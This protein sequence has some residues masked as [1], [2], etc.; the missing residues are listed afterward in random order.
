[1]VPVNMH[2]KPVPVPLPCPIVRLG[3]IPMTAPRGAWARAGARAGGGSGSGKVVGVAGIPE[4]P[5]RTICQRPKRNLEFHS[6]GVASFSASNGGKPQGPCPGQNAFHPRKG[7][8]VERR[9]R[10]AMGLPPLRRWPPGCR[11]DG[12]AKSPSVP[13]R[14][15]CFIRD[16]CP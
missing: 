7:K 12:Q 16:A 13:K 14:R 11:R 4:L 2:R 1:A 3:D 8:L 10:K 15:H 5:S 9:G 6:N